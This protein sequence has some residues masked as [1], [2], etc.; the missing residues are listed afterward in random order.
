M[1]ARDQKNRR[2]AIL[3]SGVGLGMV[4]LAFASVPLYQLFC[5][6]TG[7]AGTP[8]I[9]NTTPV[10]VET[11][12]R[13]ITVRF[14]AS[15]NSRLDWRFRPAQREIVVRP[16]EPQLAAYR[17]ENLSSA[18][19]TGTATFNVTPMKAASYFAKIECF[20]F[21][22]QQLE[23]GQR[24]EM[25]VQFYVDP[26]ILDDPDTRDVETITLSYTFFPVRDGT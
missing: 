3:L 11:A 23:P 7:Y 16:G 8:R 18:P 24:A 22:R 15:V 4:A 20:C 21:T 26:E 10:A 6:V 2:T 13:L 17:A 19:L 12:D 9:E 14:D 5:Q 25:P 1:G